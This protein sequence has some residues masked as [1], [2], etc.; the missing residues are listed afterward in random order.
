MLKQELTSSA[1]SL[2]D[3]IR[4]FHGTVTPTILYGSSCWTMTKELERRLRACQRRMLRLII[5]AR[6]RI[7]TGTNLEPWVDFIKRTTREAEERLDRLKIEDWVTAQR[8][9]KWNFARRVAT[10]ER[11]WWS[12]NAA[13]W[14]PAI[15][16][17][18]TSR[19]PGR[20]KQR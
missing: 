4:L 2:T 5:G 15:T 19:P 9:R 11:S 20:P 16:S 13:K 18:R 10:Q 17:S 3:R 6:R 1:Y 8:R 12:S 14:N 7:T